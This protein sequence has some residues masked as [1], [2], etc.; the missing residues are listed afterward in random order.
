VRYAAAHLEGGERRDIGLNG[1][2]DLDR[3]RLLDM[4]WTLH[5]YG[6]GLVC[7]VLQL[8]STSGKQKNRCTESCKNAL[9][10]GRHSLT[11][12]AEDIHL[13]TFHE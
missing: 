8:A 6:Y 5:A 13:N 11:R 10:V 4:M 7:S 3:H 9:Q 12:A 2:T 1:S